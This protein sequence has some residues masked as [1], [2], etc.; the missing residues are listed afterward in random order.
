MLACFGS[1]C[2]TRTN[3]RPESVER[4]ASNAANASRPPAEAPIPTMGIEPARAF[5]TAEFF[6]V[7]A[8]PE[9]LP[10]FEFLRMGYPSKRASDE[11]DS[12]LLPLSGKVNLRRVGDHRA[13]DP[14]R[15]PG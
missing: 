4:L 15:R 13:P 5:R 14:T 11:M 2:C 6:P 10:F 3:A 7:T 1:R 12:R 9:A 8:R